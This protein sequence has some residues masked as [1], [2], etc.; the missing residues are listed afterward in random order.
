MAEQKKTD[1]GQVFVATKTAHVK[2]GPGRTTIKKDVTRVAAGH[3]LIDA[4]PDFFKPADQGLRFEV[5]DTTDRPSTTRA[6]VPD[7]PPATPEEP[8]S[9]DYS[10]FKKAE[11]EAEVEKRNAGRGEGDQPVVVEGKGNVED[12]RAA[13][14]ADDEREAKAR[15]DLGLGTQDVPGADGS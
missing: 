15:E 4:Y 2:F 11:L 13:L 9:E 10:S 7:T 1:Q 8:K 5:E 12:L 14:V 6:T 3:P